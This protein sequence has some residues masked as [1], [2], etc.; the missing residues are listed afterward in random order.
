MEN[1]PTPLRPNN[2]QGE[3]NSLDTI[4]VI[5]DGPG[6]TTRRPMRPNIP[7]YW[8]GREPPEGYLDAEKPKKDAPP[9][10]GS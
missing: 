9:A 8:P 1:T 5:S 10:E 7:R 2:G 4:L 3:T 6:D